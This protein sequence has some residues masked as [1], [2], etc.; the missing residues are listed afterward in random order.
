[1]IVLFIPLICL[2]GFPARE[3]IT[4][5]FLNIKYGI[6][7]KIYPNDPVTA[8]NLGLMRREDNPEE[9]RKLIKKA[10]LLNHNYAVSYY[11]LGKASLPKLKKIVIFSNSQNDYITQGMSFSVRDKLSLIKTLSPVSGELWNEINEQKNLEEACKTAAGLGGNYLLFLNNLYLKNNQWNL[12]Y[13][14]IE[15]IGKKVI[16]SG[17]LVSPSIVQIQI[18]LVMEIAKTL[19]G[20]LTE[21]EEKIL[22]KLPCNPRTFELY[23]EGKGHYYRYVEEDNRRAIELFQEAIRLEPDFA[24]AYAA[25]A[26]SLTQQYGLF[27]DRKE[28]V[29]KQ[30][31]E[32]AQKALSIDPSLA[33]AYKSLGLSFS[34]QGKKD[35]GIKEYKKALLLNENYTE[36]Y[37]NLAM[38][39]LNERDLDKAFNM[40]QEAVKTNS[41]SSEAHKELAGYY[42]IKRNYE[43]AIKEYEIAIDTGFLNKHSLFQSYSNIA[44]CYKLEGNREKAV[45]FLEKALSV[46]PDNGITYFELGEIFNITG[47]EEKAIRYYRDYLKVEPSG[48][49]SIRAR[50]TLKLLEGKKGKIEGLVIG[51]SGENISGLKIIYRKKSPLSEEFISITDKRGFYTITLPCGIYNYTEVRRDKKSILQKELHEV[52][53]LPG[54]IKNLD[55]YLRDD[56]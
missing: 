22:K 43:K 38:I 3:N 47:E 4:K 25:L 49:F 48:K 14:L 9:A 36:V 13:T 7:A 6:E 24:P 56:I 8:Y 51:Q 44:L 35:E 27:N 50:T 28:A 46:N 29:I 30:S 42:L 18:N 1:M 15:I 31:I 54:Q 32:Y 39:F 33:E 40:L 5:K 45:L 34:Y 10:Y 19:T 53:V 20:N 23:L 21:M 16:A 11:D 41:S 52:K 37:I 12:N 17:I 26:D 2:T 55:L